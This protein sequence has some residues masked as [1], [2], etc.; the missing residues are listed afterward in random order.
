MG[1][2]IQNGQNIIT[3]TVKDQTLDE[4][5]N[6]TKNDKGYIKLPYKPLNIESSQVASY[7]EMKIV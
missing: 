5:E 3:V 2:I 6:R 1:K 4:N 7:K